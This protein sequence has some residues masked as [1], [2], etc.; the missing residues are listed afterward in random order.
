[1]CDYDTIDPPEQ[2][3]SPLATPNKAPFHR[4]VRGLALCTSMF[5]I[6]PIPISSS[7]STIR[8]RSLVV[9][10]FLEVPLAFEVPLFFPF[11]GRSMTETGVAAPEGLLLPSSKCPSPMR[12][13]IPERS[14]GSWPTED[15]THLHD[16]CRPN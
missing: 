7:P 10:A 6:A 8:N 1:V 4:K 16:T 13:L 12:P 3:P 5:Y 15:K 14:L 11:A 9:L 2:A